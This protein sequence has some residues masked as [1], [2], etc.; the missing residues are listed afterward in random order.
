MSYLDFWMGTTRQ[1]V[2]SKSIPLV[3]LTASLNF[4]K[5]LICLYSNLYPRSWSPLPL[6][7]NVFIC[8]WRIIALH[9]VLVSAI[10]KHESAIGKHTSLPLEPPP[11]SHPIPSRL[12]Q[13]PSLG[14]WSHTEN[15]NW[16]SVNLFHFYMHTYF[17]Q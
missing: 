13:S 17:K 12:S 7:K 3:F 4:S 16:L 8:N 1:E 2:I 9:I 10:H 14:S 11:T 15:S 5:L 6:F